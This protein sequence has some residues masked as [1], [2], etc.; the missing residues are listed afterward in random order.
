MVIDVR[1]GTPSPALVSA[2]QCTQVSASQGASVWLVLGISRGMWHAQS[3]KGLR[4]A[5]QNLGRDFQRQ[6]REPCSQAS[7]SRV[8]AGSV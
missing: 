8:S 6:L 3:L 4:L 2:L 7:R 1:E 5:S